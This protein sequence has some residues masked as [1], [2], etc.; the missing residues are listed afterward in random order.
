MKS[1]ESDTTFELI[2]AESV[3]C[4]VIM[5]GSSPGYFIQIIYRQQCQI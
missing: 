4:Q 5:Q 2:S 3:F 1:N